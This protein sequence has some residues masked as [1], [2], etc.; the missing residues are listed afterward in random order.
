ME[1]WKHASD[2]DACVISFVRLSYYLSHKVADD[3]AIVDAHA[4]PV[5]VEDPSNPHLPTNKQTNKSIPF[6]YT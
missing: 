2:V 6:S 3:P 4:R 1:L 5:G